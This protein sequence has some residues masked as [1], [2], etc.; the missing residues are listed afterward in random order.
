MLIRSLASTKEQSN[1][2]RLLTL[3]ILWD[4]SR[5]VF[6]LVQRL[7]DKVTEFV[8]E[9]HAISSLCSLRAL[10]LLIASFTFSICMPELDSYLLS[11]YKART[12]ILFLY[13]LIKHDTKTIC[14]KSAAYVYDLASSKM[15]RYSFGV[16]FAEAISKSILCLY[17]HIGTYS[18]NLSSFFLT[19]CGK[20]SWRAAIYGSHIY[21]NNLRE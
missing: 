11:N 3:F 14:Y 7:H 20:G 17:L 15:N 5:R 19:F 2:V 21:V 8:S 6:F 9:Q 18:F 4:L 12:I 1:H 10:A 16:S 13:A